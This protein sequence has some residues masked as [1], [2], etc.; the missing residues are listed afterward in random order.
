MSETPEIWFRRKT[1]GYGADPANWKG[2]AAVGVFLLLE[3]ALVGLLLVLPA[4]SA[5]GLSALDIVIYV[6]AVA[7]LAAGFLRLV[8]ARTEGG[9][10]WQWGARK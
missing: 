2:W 9:W 5:R 7:I 4:M 6:V 3:L 1:H 8:W 10:G